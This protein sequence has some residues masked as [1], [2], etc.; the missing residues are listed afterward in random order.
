MLCNICVLVC[1]VSCSVVMPL[2]L[3]LQSSPPR[4][5]CVW[6]FFFFLR[7]L[8]RQ[9]F[10]IMLFSMWQFIIYPKW[11]PV[12]D[13]MVIYLLF[14][15]NFSWADWTGVP[16]KVSHTVEPAKG[17]VT[18]CAKSFFYF[19]I[20]LSRWRCVDLLLFVVWS[21]NQSWINSCQVIPI[22]WSNSI[23]IWGLGL[24]DLLHMA[25]Q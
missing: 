11:W 9:H 22:E 24:Y 7:P 13:L 16:H 19:F 12:P 21:L 5:V 8:D 2:K 14:S 23:E 25:I 6:S 10:V 18:W 1:L 3:C 20:N 4:P 15:G 17:S